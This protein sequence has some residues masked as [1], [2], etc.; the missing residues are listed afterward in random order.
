MKKIYFLAGAAAALVAVSCARD[1]EAGPAVIQDD[2][3][4]VPVQFGSSLSNVETKAAVESW[5]QA[6]D[7][8]SG[9][10]YIYGLEDHGTVDVPAYYLSNTGTTQAPVYA[11]F[12]D[13]TKAV[14][15]ASEASL[16]GTRQRITVN[17]PAGDPDEPYYYAEDV[18]YNFFAY[19]VD[20]AAGNAP[21]P[22]VNA[23]ENLVSTITLP[24]TING[25]QDILLARTNKEEDLINRQTEG[26]RA[27]ASTANLYSA[28]SA[29]RGVQPNL[30]FEH[31]LSRFVFSV[32][33]GG[34]VDSEKITVKDIQVQSFTQGTL[35]IV[36]EPV[37][38][39]NLNVTNTGH[40]QST[41]SQNLFLVPS[42]EMS[43]LP[44][45]RL[46]TDAPLSSD[47]AAEKIHPT[48]NY[49]RIG[50]IMVYPGQDAYNFTL[51]IEQDGVSAGIPMQNL[52]IE[53]KSVVKDNV[54]AGVQFAEPGKQYN[55]NIII[56][57][58]E[59][60]AITVTLSEWN[61]VGDINIDIDDNDEI[62]SYTATTALTAASVVV[63]GTATASVTVK[64][65]GETVTPTSVTYVSSDPAVAKV[66][67]TTITGLK[68]G[69]AQI[70]A[71]I[72]LTGVEGTVISQPVT[73]TVTAATTPVEPVAAFTVQNEEVQLEAEGNVDLSTYI[74][75]AE[76][77]TG[78]VTYSV[79]GEAN[80]FE[81]V[82][83]TLVAPAA[84]EED[85]SV[86]ITVSAEPAEGFAATS[87]DITFVVPATV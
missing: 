40:T 72:T 11:P 18:K 70:Y 29:R 5:G 19:F 1:G 46:L 86:V 59:E 42:G 68:E 39:P 71:R 79:K 24:V 54:S 31:Q 49:E 6:H 9:E 47:V 25:T 36:G 57:G 45:T 84:G 4:P 37:A 75:V 20:D 65:D 13:N 80:G 77:Y 22:T 30:D 55:V 69:T 56:Y 38:T 81:L 27:I 15:P 3:T 53:M 66:E 43:Y 83:G 63:N 62:D 8:Q 33:K 87:V 23:S 17:N 50:D 35:T 67:G 44:V 34:N 16:N 2:T 58:A 85:K 48:A 10:I 28:Y 82:E 12:I 41:S 21:A 60:I 78:T 51:E 7:P 32:K 73:L 14:P 64:K 52:Q 26:F 74:T 76:G 61:E